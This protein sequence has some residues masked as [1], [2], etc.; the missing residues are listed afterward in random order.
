[1]MQRLS[2]VQLCQ[3]IA[4]Q[5]SQSLHIVSIVPLQCVCL[6]PVFLQRPNS[7]CTDWYMQPNNR[8]VIPRPVASSVL[9][10][11]LA[12]HCR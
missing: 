6:L 8:L 2:A 7:F 10:C 9:I 4:L 1:M 12:G 5:I 11:M 3:S